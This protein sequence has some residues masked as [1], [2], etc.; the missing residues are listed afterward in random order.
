MNKP[1]GS[2]RWILVVA[3]LAGA[4]AL[5]LSA[6]SAH[7]LNVL[8]SP[9]NLARLQTANHYLMYY[10]LVLLMLG[11]FYQQRPWPGLPRVSVLFTAGAGVFCGGLYI[12]CFSG[13]SSFAWLVP[14][15]GLTLLAGWLLL[16]WTAWRQGRD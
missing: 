3:A 2:G 13:I 6:S 15:G 9:E 7:V 16:A 12:L 4:A 10:S 14:L 11:L 1:P 5:V 8:V